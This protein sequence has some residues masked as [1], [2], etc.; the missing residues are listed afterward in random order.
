MTSWDWYWFLAPLVV[1]GLGW[2][3]AVL[4]MRQIDRERRH[5]RETTSRSG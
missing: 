1:A 2:G 5:E 3:A 4:F